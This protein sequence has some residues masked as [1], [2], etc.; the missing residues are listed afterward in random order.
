MLRTGEGTMSRPRAADGRG[1]GWLYHWGPEIL[2][3]VKPRKNVGQRRGGKKAEGLDKEGGRTNDL[4]PTLRGVPTA[5]AASASPA[6][7][8]EAGSSYPGLGTPT[9]CPLAAVRGRLTPD[10]FLG[11]S[12]QAPRE[13]GPGG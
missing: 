6:H 9:R 7:L 2:R 12:A 13:L 11:I 3:I 8:R 1:G 4:P 5:V 10:G